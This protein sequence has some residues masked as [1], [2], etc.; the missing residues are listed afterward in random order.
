MGN[1]NSTKT[2]K[3][4]TL[5][6]VQQ[7]DNEKFGHCSW[8]TTLNDDQTTARFFLTVLEVLHGNLALLSGQLFYAS[9]C[10]C[11]RIRIEQFC[12]SD[13]RPKLFVGISNAEAKLGEDT[14][15]FWLDLNNNDVFELTMNCDQPSIQ[16]MVS[17]GRKRNNNVDLNEYPL[18]WQLRLA[19][20][21]GSGVARL[22][23]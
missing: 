7:G 17:D 10:H 8:G 2:T 3:Q 18:P 9:G 15:G 12:G 4:P 16:V 1:T 13:F 20:K 22:L 14:G 21:G 23:P 11:I 5:E 6:I 19:V